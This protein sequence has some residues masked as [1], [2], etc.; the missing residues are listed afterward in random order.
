MLTKD[1]WLLSRTIATA[2]SGSLDGGEGPTMKNPMHTAE[3]I[4]SSTEDEEKGVPVALA[5]ALL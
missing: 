5:R 1:G 3:G 2:S 4:K